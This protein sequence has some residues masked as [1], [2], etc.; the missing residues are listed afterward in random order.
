MP[1]KRFLLVTAALSATAAAA[2]CGKEPDSSVTL[3]ANP[4]GSHYDGS[5]GTTTTPP[6][7]VVPADA[8]SAD[9][10]PSDAAPADAAPA[11]A[12]AA[13]ADAASPK[14]AQV[15]DAGPIRRPLPANPK[16]SHYDAG[17]RNKGNLDF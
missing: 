8:A 4:K 17:K 15:P 3:P 10:A 14:P 6:P 12:D 5:M 7:D 9:A 2:A 11:R 13:P 16:G 1:T